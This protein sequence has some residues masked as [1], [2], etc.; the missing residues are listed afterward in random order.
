[1]V[2]AEFKHLKKDEKE[3]AVRF[4]NNAYLDGEYIYDVELKTPQ[5]HVPA[6]WTKKDIEQWETLKSKRIDL[7]VKQPNRI[8]V[9]EIT[10]KLS[11]AAVGGV[12]TYRELYLA[13]YKPKQDVYLGVVCEVD[14]PGYHSTCQRFGIR[15][16]VV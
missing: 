14:D 8:W 15:I 13:Q 3:I 12:M 9:I 11:K 10:P 2:Q 7:V 1:M 4:R 16:W 6:H 5:I